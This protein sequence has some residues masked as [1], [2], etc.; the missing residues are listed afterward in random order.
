M[1]GH[2][3]TRRSRHKSLFSDETFPNSCRKVLADDNG[4]S[5]VHVKY[6]VGREVH[7]SPLG[8]YIHAGRNQFAH[9]GDEQE[10]GDSLKKKSA[11]FNEFTQRVFDHLVQAH[12][13]D[14][15]DDLVFD[16]GN[17]YYLGGPPTRSADIMLKVLGW[18]DYQEYEIDMKTMIGPV[19]K[20]T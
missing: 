12:Y 6:Y 17:P 3:S 1:R 4:N 5:L 7:E 10:R 2:S 20:A 19:A 8:V 13:D 11:G 15:L 14:V 9:W 16:I 18:R